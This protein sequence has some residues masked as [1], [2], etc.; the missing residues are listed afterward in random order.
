M[1]TVNYQFVRQLTQE[2]QGPLLTLYMP[3]HRTG[4][5]M[6]QDRIRLKNML[7][8][9][10]QELKI[11]P[12]GKKIDT[13]EFLKPLAVLFTEDTFWENC[14]EGLAAFVKPGDGKILR[15]PHDFAEALHINHRFHIKPLLPLLHDG[16]KFYVLALTQDS[17][18]LF[19]AT[20][21]T[22]DE[23]PLPEIRKIE[24]DGDDETL[25]F[26]AHP[27]AKPSG[28]P[29]EVMY[30]GHG[31]AKDRTKVDVENFFQRVN[32]AVAG[33][34][35]GRKEPLILAC[36]EYLGP[37]YRAANSYAGLLEV[38]VNGNPHRVH[39]DLLRQQAWKGAAAY[40]GDD[41]Q[42]AKRRFAANRTR[43]TAST[44]DQVAAAAMQGQIDT[45]FLDSTKECWGKIE[46][47]EAH[48]LEDKERGTDAVE[49]YDWVAIETIRS[50]GKVYHVDDI[51]EIESP[52]AALLRY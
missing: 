35:R 28:S 12:W 50:G 24:V 36:V 23:I 47:H 31:G 3:T 18:T 16:R 13:E 41:E 27:I 17:A 43:Q 32:D 29:D 48:V 22:I 5:E 2:E 20:K 34:L 49:L 19:E 39:P 6:R 4:R 7:T 38:Q 40:L 1:D 9:A 52:V 30:H 21:H 11:S 51:A 14:A 44:I 46:D 42:E 8:R 25:Q 37:I 26:H 15:L 10:A 33:V 45:L